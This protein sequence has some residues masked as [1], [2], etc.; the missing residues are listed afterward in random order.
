MAPVYTRH[1]ANPDFTPLDPVVELE[2]RGLFERY[3]EFT[4][5]AEPWRPSAEQL[6]GCHHS[7]NGFTLEKMT[8]P[9]GFARE[10]TSQLTRCGKL[11]GDGCFD[12]S[13]QATVTW[14]TPA[15]GGR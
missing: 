2:R 8:D 10:L 4:T 11:A 9:D 1:G 15:A 12:L 6:I 3:G 7:Q 14:G 5:S 13:V